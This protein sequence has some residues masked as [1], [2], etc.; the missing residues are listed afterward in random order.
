VNCSESCTYTSTYSMLSTYAN[1]PC[2]HREQRKTKSGLQHSFHIQLHVDIAYPRHGQC[3]KKLV[4]QHS[5]HRKTRAVGSCRFVT[6][7]GGL[8]VH[9]LRKLR[10]WCARYRSQCERVLACT[11]FYLLVYAL[12]LIL[13]Q[14]V[15]LR[16]IDNFSETQDQ[17]WHR[18]VECVRQAHVK[19][20]C[21]H[22][23][24]AATS[25]PLCLSR[26]SMVPNTKYRLGHQTSVYFYV[27]A[28][29]VGVRARRSR[30]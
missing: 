3:N 16:S 23:L 6:V 10:G 18:T 13:G 21:T 30:S 5:F 4:F 1:I 20:Y 29:R 28:A 26:L 24:A 25:P 11:L 8:P 7:V 15:R 22:L 19:P 2:P 9:T 17:P 27:P 12:Q 14:R